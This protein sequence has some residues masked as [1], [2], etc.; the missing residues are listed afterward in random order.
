MIKQQKIPP[1]YVYADNPNNT[2]GAVRITSGNFSGLI[3]QYGVVSFSEGEKEDKC[4]V[5]FTYEIIDNDKRL[6]ENKDMKDVMGL[7]LVDLL[8]KNYKDGNDNRT[9]DIE[10]LD[11]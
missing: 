7:I 5:N 3:Y 8:N 9:I 2:M 4:S 10:Q 11:S 1:K 6:P